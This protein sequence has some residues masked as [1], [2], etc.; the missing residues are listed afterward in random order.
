M[1]KVYNLQVLPIHSPLGDFQG[2]TPRDVHHV[3]IPKQVR[4]RVEQLPQL[5]PLLLHGPGQ[6]PRGLGCDI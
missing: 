3:K 4:H 6:G 2:S 5:S 1:F